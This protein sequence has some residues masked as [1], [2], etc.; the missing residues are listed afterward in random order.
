MHTDLTAE[1]PPPIAQ[2][3][4]SCAPDVTDGAPVAGLVSIVIPCYNVEAYAEAAI[5]SALEQSYARLEVI[6]VDDGSTDGTPAVIQRLID[7]RRD[8]RLRCVTQRNGGLSAA[9]NAGIAHARG[10]FIGFLD[11]DD[12]WRAD[13]LARHVALLDSKPQVGLT[14]SHSAYMSEAGEAT[15]GRL[16][17]KRLKPSLHDMLRRNHFGNGST[18]VAR[19]ACFEIAGVFREEL[20]S[21]EDY[22]MWCRILWATDYQAEGLPLPLTQYRLRATSLTANWSKFTQNADAAMAFL[23]QEMP[24]VPDRKFRQGHAEHY[25][26]ASWRAATAGQ[27]AVAFQLL[28]KALTLWPR[29]ITDLRVVGVAGALVIPSRLRFAAANAVMKLLRPVLHRR[30]ADEPAH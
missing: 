16:V 3:H 2:V 8:A 12:V 21:C 19:R 7:T 28:T 5:V 29:L 9:R 23:R 30:H 18:V 13:K 10:Q 11:G 17:A 6:A 14:F 24:C 25:R 1:R 20:K 15:S 27:N 26:I 4:A 22:E